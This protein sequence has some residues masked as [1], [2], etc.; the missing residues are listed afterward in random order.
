MD[1]KNVKNIQKFL[2][3]QLKFTP[4]RKLFEDHLIAK[5]KVEENIENCED[6]DSDTKTSSWKLIREL[7]E[8]RISNARDCMSQIRFK[9]FQRREKSDREILQGPPTTS[10]LITLLEND[11]K[12]ISSP[13]PLQTHAHKFLPYNNSI[14][15]THQKFKC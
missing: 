13:Q 2:I 7:R 4:R 10:E 15:L 6:I 8:F 1:E 14:A 11:K 5:N 3:A 12:R 9:R